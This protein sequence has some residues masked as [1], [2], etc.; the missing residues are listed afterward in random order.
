MTKLVKKSVTQENPIADIVIRDIRHISGATSVNELA[1]VL[2]RTRYALVDKKALVTADDF[3][4]FMAAKIDAQPAK[5]AQPEEAPKG[6]SYFKIAG[7]GLVTAGIA[8]GALMLAK[9]K[10]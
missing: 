7:L 9:H 4:Q 2:A 10:Q 8:T 1:R 3:L 6:M 5:V